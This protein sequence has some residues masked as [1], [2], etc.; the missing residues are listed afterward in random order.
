M[1]HFPHHHIAGMFADTEARS[2]EV[3]AGADDGIAGKYVPDVLESRLLC[4]DDG[5]EDILIH[6]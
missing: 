4:E 2:F 6:G 3:R 1:A 5:V